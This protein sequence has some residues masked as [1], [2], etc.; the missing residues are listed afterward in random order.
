MKGKKADLSSKMLITIILLIIGF[1]AVLFLLSKFMWQE[2]IDREVCHESVIFRATLPS[3]AKSYVPL[4]CKTAK[5]CITTGLIGGKCDDKGESFQGEEGITKVKVRK[6][7][8]GE[9]DIAK[10]ISQEIVSCW[11]MMGEGKVTLFSQAVVEQFGIGGE[12]Y[13]SCVI[14]SRVAFDKKDLDEAEIDLSEVNVEKYMMGYKIP[15]KDITYYEYITGEKGKFSFSRPDVFLNLK[16]EKKEG[17]EEKIVGENKLKVNVEKE[18]EE[19]SVY[20]KQMTVLFMQISSPDQWGSKKNI[21]YAGLGVAA[22]GFYLSPATAVKRL[23]TV[24][25]GWK[26]NLPLLV[27]AGVY[28][29]ANVAYNRAITAGYC[30]DVSM[31]QEAKSGCSV[32]RTMNYDAGSIAEY[33]KVI[34]SIP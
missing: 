33:C 9:R 20:D 22:G 7:E 13:P 15:G 8:E 31:G 24:V 25:A 23:V 6:G 30:G 28:Q 29:T 26:I 12:V 32:V 21:L 27:I 4:K 18:E 2:N 17:V 3:M 34:E 11:E 1:G 16:V 14:C 5:Y 19:K 10:F